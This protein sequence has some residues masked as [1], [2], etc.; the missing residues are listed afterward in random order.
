MNLEEK[1]EKVKNNIIEQ[2][3]SYI[4]SMDIC[5]NYG[6]F[7]SNFITNFDF[8]I[9][10]DEDCNKFADAL[11][12][13]IMFKLRAKFIKDIMDDKVQYDFC[14]KSDLKTIFALCLYN[15]FGYN[16]RF[17]EISPFVEDSIKKFVEGFKSVNEYYVNCV[18]NCDNNYK[19]TPDNTD[20]KY[21]SSD[22]EIKL[23]NKYYGI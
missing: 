21:P 23:Y 4:E 3:P 2:T 5:R 11:G 17:N 8:S 18:I 20:V 22:I 19:Y 1:Y 6:V 13:G 16:Q 12:E 15:T 7:L 14:T 9:I 10:P